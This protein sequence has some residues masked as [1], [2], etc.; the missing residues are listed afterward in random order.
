M[1]IFNPPLLDFWCFQRK[2]PTQLPT[3]PPTKS[4]RVWKYRAHVAAFNVDEVQKVKG[5]PLPYTRPARSWVP[6][7]YDTLALACGPSISKNK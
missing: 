1:M 6:Q 5:P 4:T 3:H 7:I 2:Q